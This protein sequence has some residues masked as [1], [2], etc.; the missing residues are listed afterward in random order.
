MMKMTRTAA[1]L[2]ERA[3]RPFEAMRPTRPSLIVLGYHRIDDT[4]SHLSVRRD[5]FRAHL[6]WIEHSGLR[7]VDVDTPKFSTD[8]V[9]GCV[10]FTFDDGYLSV[11][12]AAWPELEARGWPATAYVVSGYT[13]GDRTFPWDPAHDPSVRLMDKSA[14]RQLA[15]HGMTIGSH[16]A[17]HRYLPGLPLPEA[18]AE[19][20]DSKKALTDL[21]GRDVTTFSYPMGGWNPLLRDA[22]RQAGYRTAVTVQ[23]GR[24]RPAADL[25][26]LRRPVVESDPEDFVRIV[27]GYFDFLRPI[28]WVRERRRQGRVAPEHV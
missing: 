8:E 23:R 12:E 26:T 4:G 19:I 9:T 18:R 16:S 14:V 25:L 22:V 20:I 15:G 17:S 13:R 5:H 2:V 6:D 21:I 7:V 27:K 11:A 24:N 28:D 10:A 3:V 1:A